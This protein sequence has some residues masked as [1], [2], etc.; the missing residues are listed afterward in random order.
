MFSEM[1]PWDGMNNQGISIL[2]HSRPEMVQEPRVPAQRGSLP[3]AVGVDHQRPETRAKIRV[4]RLPRQ[5]DLL[6]I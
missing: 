3:H 4:V 1:D 2:S 5:P 6:G